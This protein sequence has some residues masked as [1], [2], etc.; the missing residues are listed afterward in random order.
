MRKK[1]FLPVLTIP[2]DLQSRY[3]ASLARNEV[4]EYQRPHYRRWL[5]FYLDFC[6]KY[7]HPARERESVRAFLRKLRDKGQAEWM[8]EQATDA[9]RLFFFLDEPAGPCPPGPRTGTGVPDPRS[10]GQVAVGTSGRGRGEGAARPAI[11]AERDQGS[12]CPPSSCMAAA[13]ACSSA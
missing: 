8:R 10:A 5:R 12:T 4:A 1:E 9:V 6:A 3:D 11:Q 13:C 7:E 2:S